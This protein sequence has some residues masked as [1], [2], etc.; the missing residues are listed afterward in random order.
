[1]NPSVQAYSKN[2][3][4]RQG[5]WRV[6]G[7]DT[8][9]HTVWRNGEVKRLIATGF[10]LPTL[11]TGCSTVLFFRHESCHRRVTERRILMKTILGRSVL[12]GAFAL[13]L[14]F[15]VWA[16]DQ[17]NSANMKQE[18]AEK[19]SDEIKNVQEAMPHPSL[20]GPRCPPR[21][22]NTESEKVTLVGSLLD[23][24][25]SSHMALPKY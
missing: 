19:N 9:A 16:A 3:A 23:M 7:M 22:P 4:R 2:N 13:T 21:S 17:T 10:C 6:D 20:W 18:K 11:E 24:P 8:S 25:K 14:V 12:A 5:F 15:P 1:M